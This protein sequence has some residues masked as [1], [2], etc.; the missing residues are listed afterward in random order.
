MPVEPI[1]GVLAAAAG[2]Y[3]AAPITFSRRPDPQLP[4]LNPMLSGA[5]HAEGWQRLKNV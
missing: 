3:A 1:V 5:C 2:V 4:V